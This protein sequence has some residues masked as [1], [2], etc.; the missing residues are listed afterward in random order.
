MGLAEIADRSRQ[1]ASRWVDRVVPGLGVRGRARGGLATR[2][3]RPA[4]AAA[5]FELFRDAAP[6]RFFPGVETGDAAEVLR[7]QVPAACRDVVAV[8]NAVCARRFDLLGYEGLSFG[9]SVDWHLDPVAGRRAPLTHWS[10]ID[11]LDAS[12][13]GD[14]KVT[15]E[16]NRHQWLLPLAQAYWLTAD[17]RYAQE[18]AD[19][20]DDWSRA[21]PYGIGIN[22]TSSLEAAFRIFSW[23]WAF[24]LI[25]DAAVL[26]PGEFSGLL[27]QIRVHASHIERYLSRYFSP[28]THLTG[29]AL[30][31]FYAGVL[32]PELPESA[33]WRRL[34]RQI[35]VEESRRQIHDDGVYFEQA[36]C[37]Q[38]Y[39]IEIY[40]HFLILA[41]RND[42][43][44]PADVRGRVVRMLEFLLAMN[45]PDGTMPQIGDADGGWLL[46]LGRRAPGDC[47]ATFAV[48]A[49]VFDREDFLWAAGG[50]TPEVLW[51]L[52]VAGWDRLKNLG[53]RPPRGPASTIFRDGGY[54]VMRSSWTRDAHQLIF[55]AG[56]LGCRVTGAHGHAD[57]LSVQCA[58]FGE[59]YLVDPGTYCYTPDLAWRDHFRGTSAHNTVTV[60]GA[61]QARPKGPFAWH[62]RPTA[63]L[64][65]WTSAADFDRVDA[66]HD[67]YQDLADPVRHR[68][69]VLFVKKRYWVIL[70]D[71]TGQAEHDVALRFQ[72]AARPVQ[73]GPGTWVA[74]HGRR[75]EGLWLAPFSTSPITLDL[76]EG[77]TNPPEGW[78]SPHYGRK[79]PAPIAVYRTRARLPL[80][81]A[82]L[83]IPAEHLEAPPRVT[84]QTDAAGRMTG[85][86]LDDTGEVVRFD[87]DTLDVDAAPAPHPDPAPARV[88]AR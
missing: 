26:S 70:D 39:T 24:A 9:E 73:A 86:R 46:P 52:G 16:L 50:P 36:T 29:E 68:R 87:D 31:L 7:E 82:T 65:E 72:F 69:R 71:L 10:R 5:A 38:R 48:A 18:A 61:P 33:R 40:L 27:A 1:Q 19:L 55:D 64:R 12:A 60:D 8:A 78:V 47:R 77:A 81:V 54:A 32:F 21:N 88:R 80:R 74:A 28:N 42:V 2:A 11:P 67:A 63:V 84:V 45:A 23:S 66:W 51:M 22:W 43:V 56:P 35:L 13:I 49:A 53:S 17:R 34:G 76:R 3:A 41:D 57:L 30:G 58:A 15:W 59:P 6:R 75:G 4:E 85:L 44:V 20:V 83:L 14:S 37:Y 25:R 79:H 62:S